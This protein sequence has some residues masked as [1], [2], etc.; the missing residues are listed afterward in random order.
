M[1]IPRNE[2]ETI[3][4][5]EDLAKYHGWRIVWRTTTSTPDAMIAKGTGELLA[6]FEHRSKNFKKHGHDPNCCDLVICWQHNWRDCPLPV[7]D[8]REYALALI[9][10]LDGERQA[11]TTEI[12]DLQTS[13][14]GLWAW[15]RRFD[16][17][18]GWIESKA[19]AIVFPFATAILLIFGIA[20]L[21]RII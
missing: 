9:R 15:Q 12:D 14:D 10:R 18:W 4:L 7:W 5:F 6:E 17:R 13:F 11:L 2:T 19:L 21:L 16:V 8:L 3:E 1:N 20:V